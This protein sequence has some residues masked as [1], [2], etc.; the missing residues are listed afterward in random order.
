MATI[1]SRN[2]VAVADE[3]GNRLDRFVQ[4]RCPDLSRS[5]CAGLIRDGHVTINGAPAKPAS[6]TRDKDLIVVQIP[7]PQRIEVAAQDIPIDIVYQDANLLVVDKPAGLTVHPAPGHPDG[8]LVN[9]LLAMVPD[10]SGVGGTLRPGIV[11]RLD[12]DTSGL[13]VVAKGDVAHH[14]LARQL[15]ERTVHKT[16]LA[17]VIG[18]VREDKGQI[19]G[20]IARHP[21][22]RKRMAILHGGRDAL[23]QYEVV[24]RFDGY[25]LVEAHPVTGRTHQIRVHFTSIGHPLVGDS[26]Y[27]KRSSLLNRHFLH[28]AK[29]AFD[30]PPDERDRYEFESPL[31]SDL[32]AVLNTIM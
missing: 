5:R 12:K 19:E 29:L 4:L 26:V 30:L 15:K 21:K 18:Q 27:G 17:L 9:A 32:R 28:A 31:P 16:Y 3:D 11:H 13:M 20:P 24:R 25:T 10:L 2:L 22:N 23:T 1:D 8:T 14:S 7:P 6:L